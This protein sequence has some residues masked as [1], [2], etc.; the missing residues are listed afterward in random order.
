MS[1]LHERFRSLD[2][3]APPELWAEATDRAQAA[4]RADAGRGTTRVFAL[5]AAA[6][7][8]ALAVVIG[9]MLRPGAQVGGPPA[10]E[11]PSATAS[12]EPSPSAAPSASAPASAEPSSGVEPAFSCSLPLHLDASGTGFPPLLLQYL[13]LGTHEGYDRIVFEYDGGTPAVD[14]NLAQPPYVQNPSGLPMTVSGEPVYQ[15][16][17]HGGTKFDMETGTMQ[18]TGPTNFEPSYEQIVQF[19]ESGD[20]EATH[21][22]YLGVNGGSC[23]RVFYLDDPDRIVIDIQH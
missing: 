22:W 13:R 12:E 5:G 17:L 7:A 1:D 23:L 9:L 18:Y 19:V 10:S 20:F 16:T 2:R 4:E 21:S 8:L 15:V 3:L 6:A 14:I 11:T